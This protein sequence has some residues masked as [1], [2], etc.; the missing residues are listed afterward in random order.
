MHVFLVIFALSFLFLSFFPLV[1][2]KDEKTCFYT[3]TNDFD[4]WKACGAWAGWNTQQSWILQ[5]NVVPQFGTGAYCNYTNQQPCCYFL[6]QKIAN[7]RGTATYQGRQENSYLIWRGK[8]WPF[9]VK[10]EHQLHFETFIFWSDL[11]QGSKIFSRG[12]TTAEKSSI[13]VQVFMT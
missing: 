11:W 1:T 7:G 2:E 13:Q 6:T 10:E 4:Q 9:A 3:L 12:Y 5:K 8:I